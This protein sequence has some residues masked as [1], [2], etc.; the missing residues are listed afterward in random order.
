M[1]AGDLVGRGRELG[2]LDRRLSAARAGEGG[3]VLV[4]GEAGAGKT[5][6]AHAL[7][8]RARRAGMRVAWGACLEG[9]GTAPY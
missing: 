7:S 3:L 1:P 9:A 4:E 8:G 2:L 5:A 6:P